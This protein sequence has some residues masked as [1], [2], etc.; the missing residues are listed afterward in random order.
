M[1]PVLT[2]A[3]PLGGIVL[4]S[5]LDRSYPA[6]KAV[7]RTGRTALSRHF[8]TRRRGIKELLAVE[9]ITV[10]VVGTRR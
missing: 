2:K 3:V 9:D 1:R 10:V 4:A 6:A 5:Q 7:L 8:L